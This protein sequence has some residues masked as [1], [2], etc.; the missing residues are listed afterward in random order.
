MPDLSHLDAQGRARMVDVA[1]KPA[2][3]RTARAEG[4]IT[5]HAA[6]LAAIRA[7]TVSKGNVLCTAEIA[8]V[9][10]GKRC[11]ELIPLCHPLGLDLLRVEAE[12][13]DTG[14]RIEASARCCGKTG[15]EM[16]A[17]CAV[18]VALLTVYDMCKA[19]DTNM[20]IG[21]VRL[22]E[23]HKEALT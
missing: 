5:L 17:L 1:D 16:E 12:L 14:V 19:V 15:V 3:R 6:T 13:C 4:Y 21:G 23:K 2:Q 20:I 10:A 7:D 11:G 9:Q 8:G 18:Q 22:L